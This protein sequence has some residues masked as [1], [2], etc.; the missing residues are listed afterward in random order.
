MTNHYIRL[1]ALCLAAGLLVS[2][3]GCKPSDAQAGV[4]GAAADISG[5]PAFSDF[6]Q[7]RHARHC[8]KVTSAPTPAQAAALVQCS[9]ETE[10]EGG[11]TPLLTLTTD[12]QVEMGDGRRYIAGT[13]DRSDIDVTAKVY[14]LR[15][16]GTMWQCFPATDRAPGKNC[17][18]Y[19][20]APTGAGMCYRT[21]FHD[22]QCVMTTGSSSQVMNLKGPTTY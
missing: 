19:P 17:L 12:V 22:W 18:K 11:S 1:I 3:T 13:D 7:A 2:V 15:G 10:N 5:P 6:F 4:S 21:N 14:P 9:T 16:Q 20:A 8:A